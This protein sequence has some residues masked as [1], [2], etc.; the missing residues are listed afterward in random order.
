M[1]L[2]I[3]KSTFYVKNKNITADTNEDD[4]D[5]PVVAL[6]SPTETT[7]LQLE[8]TQFYQRSYYREDDLPTFHKHKLSRNVGKGSGRGRRG[9][10]VRTMP[11][12]PGQEIDRKVLL[13]EI[14]MI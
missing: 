13:I 14:M 10:Q 5:L 2:H 11:V 8:F 12:P 7:V 1:G 4:F 3:I 6:I 9:D